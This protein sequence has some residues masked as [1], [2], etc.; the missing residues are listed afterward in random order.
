MALSYLI[1]FAVLTGCAKYAVLMPKLP[2]IEEEETRAAVP[3]PAK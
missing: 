1:V 2:E 3:Q